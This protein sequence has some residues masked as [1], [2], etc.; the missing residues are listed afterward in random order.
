METRDF[1]VSTEN[2]CDMPPAY[3][4][5]QGVNRLELTFTMDDVEYPTWGENA[6]TSAQFYHM[7]R[8]GSIGKT[9]QVSV[10]K[11]AEAFEALVERGL[12][13]FHLAFSSNLSGTY[14]SCSIAAQDVMA[15]HPGSRIV[16]VDSLAASMGQGLLLHYVLGLKAAGHSLEDCRQ[17]VEK[18]KLRFCHN[19]IVDD[20]HFL[21]RG[22]RV[23]KAA[24]IV[25]T[26]LGIKPVLH[27]DDE[28]RLVNVGKVRG[29]KQA[30]HWLVDKMAQHLDSSATET[31]FI[32]HGDCLEDA[33]YV[34]DLVKERFAIEDIRI[35]DVGPVIGS[36]SGPGTVALFFIGD[37]RDV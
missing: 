19:F 21:H 1:V 17:L 27:V 15:R 34:A 6:M 4:R 36:H 11:A 2:T 8:E 9:A 20:L 22:G 35:G 32:S 13:V 31:V 33:Q 26:A 3:Y 16:V 29:R 18:N 30:L 24:A 5:E 25:G 12:D 37:S 14:Q 23:S 7:L 28:G 10:E